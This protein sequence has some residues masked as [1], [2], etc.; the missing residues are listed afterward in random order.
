[1]KELGNRERKQSEQVEDRRRIRRRKIPD[2]AKERRMAHVDGD[3]QH[4]VQREEHRN[5]D[6]DRQTA[7][8]RIDLLVLVERH[9]LLLLA[10]LIVFIALANP[11]H[12][13]LKLLHLRHRLVGLVGERE[14]RQLDDDRDR[15]DREAE[16]AK[17]PV[18][19]LDQP[20]QRLGDEVEPAPIDQQVELQDVEVI[21]IALHQ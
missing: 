3:E 16:V 2:P 21:G 5:L 9:Q 20:E 19:P 18:E 1:M 12:V 13:G 17:Q 6:E 4:L 10:H 8:Q 11:L 14:E 15:Q 7:C